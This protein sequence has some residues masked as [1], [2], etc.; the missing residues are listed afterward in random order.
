MQIKYVAT[1]Q[2]KN[3][4]PALIAACIGLVLLT[5]NVSRYLFNNKKWVVQPALVADRSGARM[6]SYNPRIA[7]LMKRL[8]AGS[9]YDRNDVLLATSKPEMI[10]QQKIFYLMRDCRM[11]N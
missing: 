8:Q 3:L 7:I 9:L 2:D 4:M 1:Q 6:F 10:D 11:I 5:I